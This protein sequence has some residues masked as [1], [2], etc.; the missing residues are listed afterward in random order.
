VK[1]IFCCLALGSL[2]L[3]NSYGQL[4][5]VGTLVESLDAASFELSTG[6]LI[7]VKGRIGTLTNL[8][9]VLDTGATRSVVDRKIV[10][11]L[12]VPLEGGHHQVFSFDRTFNLEQAKFHDLQF[13]P[14]R[15]ENLSMLVADLTHFSDFGRDVDALIGMDLLR[16]RN[17]AI[18]Y[19]SRKVLFSPF[20]RARSAVPADSDPLFF[21]VKILIQEHPVHLVVDTGIEGVLLYEDSL[22]ENVPKL[23]IEG[24]T[25]ATNL[26]RRLRAKWATLPNIT[27]GAT[28][29]N[30]R[31]LLVKASPGQIPRGVDGYIGP[32]SLNARRIEFNFA[33]RSL[34]LYK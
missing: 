31:V 16:L 2:L 4:H 21:S 6:Y 13:G 1:S 34:T 18:D 12:R 20:D 25:E 11:R 17:F 9:F 19:D 23:R 32:A 5:E 8:R 30:I 26:G 14:V 22:L 15:L 29:S 28:N 24:G 33:N 7:V 27:I 10:D 3:K